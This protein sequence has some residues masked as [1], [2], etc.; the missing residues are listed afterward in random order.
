MCRDGGLDPKMISYGERPVE[1]CFEVQYTYSRNWRC[2]SQSAFFSTKERRRLSSDLFLCSTRPSPMG[3]QGVVWDF[4][5][6]DTLQGLRICGFS[7]FRVVNAC[8][9][10]HCEDVSL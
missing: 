2:C 3:W 6:W 4:A 9:V 10:S 5:I 8:M 1:E 7:K